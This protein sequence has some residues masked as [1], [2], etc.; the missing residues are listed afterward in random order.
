MNSRY[1]VKF[2]KLNLQ[3]QENFKWLSIA[4]WILK[5]LDGN[6]GDNS[7]SLKKKLFFYNRSILFAYNCLLNNYNKKINL[8]KS[9][10]KIILINLIIFMISQYYF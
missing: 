4:R 8:W 2:S 6:N 7:K 5:S 9:Y 1:L 10:F 3:N